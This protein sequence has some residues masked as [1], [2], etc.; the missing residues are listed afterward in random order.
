V[1]NPTAIQPELFPF[2]AD[3]VLVNEDDLLSVSVLDN[4]LDADG[5]DILFVVDV[6]QS[7][8]R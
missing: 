1:K 4:D 8:G 3:Q 6:S 7:A 5:L 2:G